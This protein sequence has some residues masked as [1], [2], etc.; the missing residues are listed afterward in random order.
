MIE[1]YT[2]AV[3]GAVLPSRAPPMHQGLPKRLH[4]VEF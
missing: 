3:P 2:N 1:I 4:P